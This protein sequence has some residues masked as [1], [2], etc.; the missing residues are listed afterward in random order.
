MS[1]FQ[2]KNKLHLI[3]KKSDKNS[4]S[5]KESTEDKYKRLLNPALAIILVTLIV[6]L[7]IVIN[8]TMKLGKK[9][10]K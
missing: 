8:W 4:S 3:A 10:K 7:F 6:A 5:K 9:K 1:L 2:L